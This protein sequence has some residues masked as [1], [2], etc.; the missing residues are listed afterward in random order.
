MLARLQW[1]KHGFAN[2]RH[3]NLSCP[4]DWQCHFSRT[5]HVEGHWTG[6]WL[7][8]RDYK[9][10]GRVKV[11]TCLTSTSSLTRWPAPAASWPAC[12]PGHMS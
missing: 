5:S 7:H 3:A 8:P 1:H 2:L 11:C 6:A 4:E 12:L 9:D 10:L